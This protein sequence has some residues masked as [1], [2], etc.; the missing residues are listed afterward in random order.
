MLAFTGAK[1]F[2]AASFLMIE[3]MIHKKCMKRAPCFDIVKQLSLT[4][5]PWRSYRNLSTYHS[6]GSLVTKVEILLE[7]LRFLLDNNDKAVI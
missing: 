6:F 1:A 5:H 2:E 4:F 3:N 7:V